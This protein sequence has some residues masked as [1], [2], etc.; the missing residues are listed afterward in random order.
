M[1]SYTLLIHPSSFSNEEIVLNK[2]IFSDIQVNDF[3]RILLINPDVPHN[4]FQTNSQGIGENTS[5]SS[6]SQPFISTIMNSIQND[7]TT[8]SIPVSKDLFTALS[9]QGL[10]F[11][12]S[13]LQ[14]TGGRLEVSLLK[15]I[16]ESL[17][18]KPYSR[19]VV[20]KIHNILAYQIDF[21]EL[22]FKKQF[23][24]RGNMWKF[25]KSMCGRSGEFKFHSN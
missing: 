21:V 11:K 6:T 13:S 17:N 2:E 15:Q 25:K 20:A 8:S 24:Q 7:V 5:T 12:V 9:T 16:A 19:V 18:I 3:V 23:F 10:I 22:T 4:N 1:L 14:S